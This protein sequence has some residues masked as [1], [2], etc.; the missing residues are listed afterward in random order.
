MKR[1]QKRALNLQVRNILRLFL[2][3][4][5]LLPGCA[6]A[7]RRVDTLSMAPPPS[8]MGVSGFYHTVER[9]QTLYRIAKNYDLDWHVLMS[10]NHISDP[11]QLEVGQKVFIPQQAPPIYPPM[12][13]GRLSAEDIRQLVGPKNTASDWR[14]ITVHHS[15]TLQGAAALFDKDHKRRHMGGLFYHFVIGNGTTTS[16]GD[17][18]IGWRW[19][20]Q[21]KA[22]RPFDIQICLVGD[23]NQQHVSEPQFSTLVELI[24]V[25]REEYDI[26]IQNIR[27]HEDIPGKHTA[28]PGS[29]FPFQRLINELTAREASRR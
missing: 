24:Q 15:G 26:P 7:P 6:R 8:A 9:G 14:T 20:K 22:N 1:H 11:S 25:L 3:L 21:V 19:K 17:L 18:E 27:R 2:M 28:C 12:A 16:D 13:G 29:H 5:F 23:F 10:V 4:L